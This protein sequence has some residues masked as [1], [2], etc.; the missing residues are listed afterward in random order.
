MRPDAI[1]VTTPPTSEPITL[2]EAQAQCRVEDGVDDTKLNALI[3]AAREQAESYT[4]RRL[5][6]QT[7]TARYAAWPTNGMGIWLPGPPLQ[8]VESIKYYDADGVE[9]TMDES[10]Y[11]VDTFSEPGRV[12]IAPTASWPRLESGNQ[13]PIS[14]EYIAGY[15]SA[16]DVPQSI[17]LGMLMCI[18]LWYRFS[19]GA[20]EARIGETP[21]GAKT[22]FQQ[23]A[24]P[25]GM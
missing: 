20:T 25:W 1:T 22:L 14:V 13:L 7:V 16:S 4:Q 12:Q 15:E 9:Q 24:A 2:A 6:T 3:V 23:A 18:A 8:S 11:R 10:D 19:E 17:K 21:F 5:M